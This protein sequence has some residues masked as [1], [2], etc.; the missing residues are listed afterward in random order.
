MLG[1]DRCSLFLLDSER[2]ELASYFVDGFSKL[3]LSASEGIAGL[4]ASTGSVL[5]ISDAYS[6]KRFNSRIDELSGYRTRNL[7][8]FPIRAQSEILGVCQM[9]NKVAVCSP[10]SLS[11]S[12]YSHAHTLTQSF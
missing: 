8:C 3:T 4:V 10:Y 2:Q 1:C 12:L 6:D 5:N 9:I 7:L 11:L